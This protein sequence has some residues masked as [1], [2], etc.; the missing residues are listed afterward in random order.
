MMSA[1]FTIRKFE[2]LSAV[3]RDADLRPSAARLAIILVNDFV[4]RKEF[5]DFGTLSAWPSV[6]TLAGILGMTPRGVQKVTDSLVERGHLDRRIGGGFKVPNRYTL[7]FKDKKPR[8]AVQGNGSTPRTAV[9]P[10]ETET[11][12][13]RSDKPRT[14]AHRNSLKEAIE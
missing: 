9:H 6:D 3:A 12:N 10:S 7:R 2:W 8:T 13:R 5:L 4:N 14:G 1:E 11:P